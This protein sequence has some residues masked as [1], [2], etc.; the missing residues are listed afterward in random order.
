[1]TRRLQLI[2]SQPSST[3]APSAPSTFVLLPSTQDATNNSVG[4]FFPNEAMQSVSTRTAHD[5]MDAVQALQ[6]LQ[7]L[8]VIVDRVALGE[9]SS[10]DIIAVRTADH[11]M[12]TACRSA[13]LS[14]WRGYL[15]SMSCYCSPWH[16]TTLP[17]ACSLCP[18]PLPLL[19]AHVTKSCTNL[20]L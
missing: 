18:A 4:D 19:L 13:S 20:Q 10:G 11:F 16:I 12:S 6:A 15:C 2:S 1:M 7:D 3:G 8:T 9:E 5:Q 14:P 17:H